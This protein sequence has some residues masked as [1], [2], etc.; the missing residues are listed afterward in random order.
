MKLKWKIWIG[1][2]INMELI[3]VFEMISATG[4]HDGTDRLTCQKDT[5]WPYWCNQA[6]TIFEET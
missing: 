2:F 6:D 3:N 5:S 4:C 1:L